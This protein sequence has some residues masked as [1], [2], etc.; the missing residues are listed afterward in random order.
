MPTSARDFSPDDSITAF[1]RV[2]Q[3]RASSA[4]QVAVVAR[5]VDVHDAVVFEQSSTLP[6]D[7]FDDGRAAGYAVD[8]PLP[9][10]SHGPYLLSISATAPGGLSTRQDLL[11]KV[12]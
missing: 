8:L 4:Q 12:R 11:F 10:L 9:Q 3:A 6:S 5:V 2:L 7:A 1:L